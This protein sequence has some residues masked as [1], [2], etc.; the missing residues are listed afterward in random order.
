MGAA[1][2]LA[3]ADEQRAGPVGQEEP[4]VR[5]EDDRVRALDPREGRRP[6]AGEEEE[7]AVGRVDVEPEPLARGEIRERRQV[8]DRARVRRAG[9]A[10]DEKGVRPAAR[11]AASAAA[12]ASR[13]IRK[14]S[15]DAISR[16]LPPGNPASIAA[17]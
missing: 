13:R 17:F 6:S 14:R 4:L 9:V 1:Q 11:S 15:S 5:V 12:S 8:V 16:T 3:V 2:R 7:P 10:D